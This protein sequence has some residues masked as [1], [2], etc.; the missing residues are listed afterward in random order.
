LI[1]NRQYIS[2]LASLVYSYIAF[3]YL[4]KMPL[5]KF[6]RKKQPQSQ[7]QR[8]QAKTTSDAPVDPISAKPMG[9][10]PDWEWRQAIG[11]VGK[12]NPIRDVLL[13][14][15]AALGLGTLHWALSSESSIQSITQADS[16][17]QS[18]EQN[19]SPSSLSSSTLPS[20]P[21]AFYWSSMPR[22]EQVANKLDLIMRWAPIPLPEYAKCLN[23]RLS[24]T[25]YF[26]Q[27]LQALSSPTIEPSNSPIQSIE[28]CF[29]GLGLLSAIG[30]IPCSL[31]CSTNKSIL[32]VNFFNFFIIRF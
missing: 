11:S 13:V 12:G 18:A 22:E 28:A 6:L 23:E 16:I 29:K 15:G 25:R 14:L 9:S 17:D 32:I 27:R 8:D 20:D 10:V 4:G 7:E 26:A 1:I 31:H 5:P 21:F 30:K 24:L 3:F 2:Y 19:S